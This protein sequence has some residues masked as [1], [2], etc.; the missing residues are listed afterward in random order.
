MN[1]N[2]WTYTPLSTRNKFQAI[3]DAT[4]TDEEQMKLIE[5]AKQMDRNA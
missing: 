1:G 3:I 2:S 5:E 4:W